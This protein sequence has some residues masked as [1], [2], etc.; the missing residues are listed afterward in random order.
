[1]SFAL[2]LLLLLAGLLHGKRINKRN[3]SELAELMLVYVLVGYCGIYMAS[4]SILDLIASF[5]Q[6]TI[7]PFPAGSP[8]QQFFGFSFL[9]MSVLAILSF[10]YRGSYLIPPVIGWS[11]F[12]LGATYIHVADEFVNK[13]ISFSS[14]LSIF[15]SHGLVA[16]TMIILL[17]TCNAQNRQTS[18]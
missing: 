9:G 1:M 7:F 6:E 18:I 13:S 2:L 17:L 3:K 11:I 15:S 12:W 5:R 16:L 10:R 14:L 4:A 8:F